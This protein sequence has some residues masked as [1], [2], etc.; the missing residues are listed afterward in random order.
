MAAA[1]QRWR[2]DQ[3]SL[4]AA[5]LVFIDETGTT[6]NMA[7]TRGR[8]RR[9]KRLI[10]RV[11]HGHWKVTTFV[12]GLRCGAVTAPF[13]IDEPM[14]GVIFL[15]YVRRCLAPTD[16][17]WGAE[18]GRSSLPRLA[19]HRGLR[20]GQPHPR[21]RIEYRAAWDVR[22]RSARYVSTP[23]GCRPETADRA[24]RVP[25]CAQNRSR[26]GSSVRGSIARLK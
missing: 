17:A 3:P 20:T 2:Q 11:P 16:R 7:R 4:E 18:T 10:G 6:T 1:R 5:R 9:G 19:R 21:L 15:T 14:N 24:P 23:P 22:A 26:S 25:T 12:A 8:A 13:V